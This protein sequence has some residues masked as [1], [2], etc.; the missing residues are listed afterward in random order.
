MSRYSINFDRLI[1]ML[2]PYYLRTRKY[3]LFLQAL[4]SPLQDKNKEFINF[5]KEKKIEAAMTSQVILFTWYLNHKYN[6][7]FVDPTD[8]IVIEDII[9][10]GV[11]VY[12]RA[13]PNQTPYTVWFVTDNWDSVKDTDEEPPIFFYKQENILINKTSFSVAVPA[14]NISQEDFVPMIA[15]TVKMYRIAGKTFQIKISEPK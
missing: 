3:V 8:S 5:A 12:R 14:I 6:K 4:V 2:V 11:P 10:I 9:D 15:N 13:D 7:Y 1:N